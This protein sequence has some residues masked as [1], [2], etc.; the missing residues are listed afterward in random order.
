MRKVFVSSVVQGFEDFR[1]A[2]RAA[3]ELMGD[4]A[5]MAEDFGARSYSS[6]KACITEAEQCDIYLV[7]LAERYG[8]TDDSGT[9]VTEAEYEAAK[10]AGKPIIAFIKRG[11]MEGH[12]SAFRK[13]IEDY[14]TGV[15]RATF[16]TPSELKDEIVRAL[17]N[18]EQTYQ[19]VPGNVFDDRVNDSLERL[20]GTWSKRPEI[21]VAFWPQPVRSL[22]V[23]LLES[24]LDQKFTAMATTGLVLLRDGYEV[25]KGHAW[26]GLDCKETQIAWFDDGLLLLRR[27]ATVESDD[28]G[29]SSYYASPTRIKDTVLAASLIAQAH[30]AWCHIRLQHMEHVKVA[31]P[32]RQR[33]SSISLRSFGSSED[34]ISELLIPL[35]RARYEELID[36]AIRRFQRAFA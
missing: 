29:F 36:R 35:T 10:A 12:Q 33:A 32:P 5:V 22:D 23:V 27:A 3:I 14:S 6:E 19:A 4:R 26:T 25:N 31:E 17:R 1:S 8:F 20:R 16:T 15:F 34:H 30:G 18:L 28:H 13:K 9:S 7:I 21:V 24:Q 11:E 2:A